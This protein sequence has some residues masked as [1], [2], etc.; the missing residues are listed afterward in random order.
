MF[1]LMHLA[2]HDFRFFVKC[3][4]GSKRG[5]TMQSIKFSMLKKV[6]SMKIS[7]LLPA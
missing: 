5:K 3:G 7:V 2:I 4:L 1:M 6:T